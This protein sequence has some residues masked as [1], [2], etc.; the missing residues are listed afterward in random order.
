MA[1]R[2]RVPI[3]GSL[4]R[5]TKC[6]RLSIPLALAASPFGEVSVDFS[7]Y[8]WSRDAGADR[9]HG[10]TSVFALVLGASRRQMAAPVVDL[11]DSSSRADDKMC[12]PKRRSFVKA[13]DADAPK[14]PDRDCAEITRTPA[15]DCHAPVIRQVYVAAVQLLAAR[16]AVQAAECRQLEE[17]ALSATGGPRTVYSQT[18]LSRP[19][20]SAR[21]MDSLFMSVSGTETAHG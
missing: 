17:M 11:V 16:A 20:K 7:I 18:A 13:I 5:G 6:A 9:A 8:S 4:V 19:A 14:S 12:Q 21:R 1:D 10:Q 2:F 3:R 15:I